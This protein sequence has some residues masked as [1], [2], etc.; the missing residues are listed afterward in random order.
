VITMPDVWLDTM[1]HVE[2]SPGAGML[3][4]LLPGVAVGVFI[5]RCC[6]A[7]GVEVTR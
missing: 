3:R 4:L 7:G 2:V 1:R 6:V 5:Y